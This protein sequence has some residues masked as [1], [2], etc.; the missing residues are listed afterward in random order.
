MEMILVLIASVLCAFLAI[1]LCHLAV[2]FQKPYSIAVSTILILFITFIIIKK[3][4]QYGLLSALA[5]LTKILIAAG[6][7]FL[8]FILI[9]NGK[10]FLAL[11]SLILMCALL[12]LAIR[13]LK[14]EGT[15][16]A[17]ENSRK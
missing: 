2:N 10:R 16:L 4:K 12:F 15:E 11:F 1:P 13:F 8:T 7:L 3:I 6:G 5:F 14:S 17:G 9:L